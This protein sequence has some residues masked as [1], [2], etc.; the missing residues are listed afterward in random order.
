MGRV[1]SPDAQHPESLAVQAFIAQKQTE[2]LDRAMET[3][4]SCPDAALAAE[5][6]RL[7][8]TLG[9]YQLIGAEA[10]LRSLE[11]VAA[12]PGANTEG[13]HQA[14]VDT[15]AALTGVARDLDARTE[16]GSRA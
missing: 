2:I 9:T 5:A 1:T 10:A 3:V 11:A 16:G 8:G 13:I 14:R 12:A 4:T 7:A 15:L 6:H